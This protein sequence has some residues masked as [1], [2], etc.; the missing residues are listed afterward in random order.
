M[1]ACIKYREWYSVTLQS[2]LHIFFLIF[3]NNP[4]AL[5]DEEAM[6][7][8]WVFLK[9]SFTLCIWVSHESLYSSEF[10]EIT[11]FL[12]TAGKQILSVGTNIYI[13][14][15]VIYS[16]FSSTRVITSS[17]CLWHRKT[18]VA[19]WTYSRWRRFFSPKEKPSNPM[20]GY[21]VTPK[22]AKDDDA[23][24]FPTAQRSNILCYSAERMFPAQFLLSLHS[25]NHS[26]WYHKWHDS[27]LSQ[28]TNIT[29]KNHVSGFSGVYLSNIC[30]SMNTWEEAC[31]TD[32]VHD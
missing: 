11:G 7:C 31:Q 16:Q 28:K 20:K 14:E 4:W 2:I 26:L 30:G 29:D 19:N 23:L 13:W 24:L 15:A 27:I 9:R 5:E 18:W 6:S 21:L 32:L 3:H 22:T 12:I 17:A 8:L 1:N 25:N 10:I